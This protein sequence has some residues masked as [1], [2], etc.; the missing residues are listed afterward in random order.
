MK[1][2]V[3]ILL[4]LLA[5]ISCKKD[6]NEQNISG[7]NCINNNCISVETNATYNTLAECQLEC[8]TTTQKQGSV[9]ITLN[10]DIK[11]YCELNTWYPCWDVVVG[12]GYSQTEVNNEAYFNHKE[13][14]EPGIYNVV[15]LPVGTYY[16]RAKKTIRQSCVLGTG[17][18]GPPAP[19]IKSGTFTI[20]SN[21][22]KT[23]SVSL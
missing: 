11:R 16:Y 15:N 9:S 4:S 19:V 5:L 22:N 17:P 3:K 23:I 21:Y 1:T 6:V 18:C 8:K 14:P 20:T 2:I 12:L 10:W 7:Y 13:L